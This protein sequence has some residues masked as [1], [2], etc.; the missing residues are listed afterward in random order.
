MFRTI[1]SGQSRTVPPSFRN[2]TCRRAEISCAWSQWTR[3]NGRADGRSDGRAHPVSCSRPERHR[4]LRADLRNSNVRGGSSIVALCRDE[5]VEFVSVNIP[6][7][8]PPKPPDER[9]EQPRH[10]SHQLRTRIHK[11]AGSFKPPTE[12]LKV[13]W[14]VTRPAEPTGSRQMLHCI[15]LVLSVPHNR[16]NGV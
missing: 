15:V 11:R 7:R 5:P 9:A 3:T 10:A 1:T 2:L 14:I 8:E 16:G 6:D 13:T 12:P 4:Y